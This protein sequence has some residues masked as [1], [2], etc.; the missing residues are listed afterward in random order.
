M[1]GILSKRCFAAFCEMYED[2]HLNVKIHI[3]RA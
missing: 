2:E 1:D 3:A